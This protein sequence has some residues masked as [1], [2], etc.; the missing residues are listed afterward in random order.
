MPVARRHAALLP[1]APARIVFDGGPELLGR[2]GKAVGETHLGLAN[3]D[4]D[5]DA[6]DIEDDG[7]ESGFRHDQR[8]PGAA[9]EDASVAE[10]A[11][12]RERRT[13]IKAGNRERTTTTR[14]T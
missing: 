8:S 7:T 2:E 4:T 1:V 3:I 12:R 14:M 10:G 9:A 11:E 13:P 6:A 5:E